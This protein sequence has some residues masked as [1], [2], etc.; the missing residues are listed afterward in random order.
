MVYRYFITAMQEKSDF[1]T[2]TINSVLSSSLDFLKK[3]NKQ[4]I[5]RNG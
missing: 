3:I 2:N 1:L 4:I 5:I